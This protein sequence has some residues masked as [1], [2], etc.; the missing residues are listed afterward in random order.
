MD[1]ADLSA[2]CSRRQLALRP[3]AQGR[4]AAAGGVLRGW[5]RCATACGDPEAR[6]YSND[7]ISPAF[8]PGPPNALGRGSRFFTLNDGMKRCDGERMVAAAGFCPKRASFGRNP[9]ADG[10]KLRFFAGRR[11]IWGKDC[12]LRVHAA[13][14]GCER[15]RNGLQAINLAVCGLDFA[16]AGGVG[17]G[18]A[19]FSFA[20]WRPCHGRN[21]PNGP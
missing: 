7:A 5:R 4:V 9:L 14:G 6:P 13:G 12:A 8:A 20:R 1:S 10:R 18:T 19:K 11:W 2:L 16:L 17:I 3:R 21:Q 15:A